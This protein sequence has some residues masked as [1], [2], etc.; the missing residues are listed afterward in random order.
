[1]HHR[2]GGIPLRSFLHEQE[3]ERLADNHAS[4]EHDDVRAAISIPLSFSSR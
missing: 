3:R 1:M 4:A 2:H